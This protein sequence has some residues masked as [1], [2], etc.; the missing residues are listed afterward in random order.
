M[1]SIR[2]TSD[3]HIKRC[4]EQII[5]NINHFPNNWKQKVDSDDEHHL[6]TLDDMLGLRWYPRKA[7][8]FNKSTT[9]RWRL[10]YR[11]HDFNHHSYDLKSIYWKDLE[12]IIKKWMETHEDSEL[13]KRMEHLIETTAALK[14]KAEMNIT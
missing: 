1:T 5:E 3:E 2:T 4:I 14:I 8:W 10:S 9:E 11:D 7:G 13:V 12:A 6:K